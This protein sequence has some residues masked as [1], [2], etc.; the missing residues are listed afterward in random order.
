MQNYHV[1][2]Y[3]G[4]FGFIKPWTAVRDDQIYSQ[5]FLTP[6]IVEGMRE[7]LGVSEILRHKLSHD[8]FSRQ[9]EEVQSKAVD[10][11]TVK[12][13]NEIT[14]N[15]TT[16]ILTRGVMINPVLHLVFPTLQEAKKASMEHLCLCRNEDLI[17]PESRRELSR[18]EFDE[19]E[20]FELIFGQG[21][22]AFMVGYNR[23]E[24]GE[25]MFG[26]LEITGDPVRKKRK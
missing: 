26:T 1:V 19:I 11:R 6:S 17:Y 15:R 18:G 25:P 20:G 22:D 12:K 14:F 9:Q 5:Q 2:T 3:T 4:T 8:G 10:V 16:S 21:E 24:D 7:K 23:F 13:R